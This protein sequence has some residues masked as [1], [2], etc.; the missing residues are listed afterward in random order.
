[1]DIGL[2]RSIALRAGDWEEMASS[3]VKAKV[4]AVKA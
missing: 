4:S 2:Q 1:M 3:F